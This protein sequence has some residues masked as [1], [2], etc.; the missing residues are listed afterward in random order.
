MY[1][2]YEKTLINTENLILIF[3]HTLVNFHFYII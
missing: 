3:K 1:I 2:A